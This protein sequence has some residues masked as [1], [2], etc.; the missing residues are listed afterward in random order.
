MATPRRK[1]CASIRVLDE[2]V[3]VKEQMAVLYGAFSVP[4]VRG[5]YVSARPVAEQALAVAAKVEDPEATA[6][7]NRMMGITE[8]ATGEFALSVSHL[9]RAAE[10]YAPETGNITDLR[11]SQDHAVWSLSL[12]A[13]SLWPLGEI[14]R[15]IEASAAGL[16]A[17]RGD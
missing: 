12:L 16:G 1:R 10:L 11:Y 6:F 3:P 4:F 8:W 14:D 17:S 5:E 7:A 15:A 2:T 13:L 9:V